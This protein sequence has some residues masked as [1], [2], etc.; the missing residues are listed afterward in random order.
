PEEPQA[1][2]AASH[3]PV[4]PEAAAP[5]PA[6]DKFAAYYEDPAVRKVVENFQGR[7]VGVREKKKC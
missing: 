2:R 7:I 4:S 3:E 5:A 1:D 6:K